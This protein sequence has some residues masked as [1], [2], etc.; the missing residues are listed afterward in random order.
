MENVS[1]A[2]EKGEA[3]GF[4]KILIDGESKRILWRVDPGSRRR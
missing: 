2:L 3:K 1:R 4:M